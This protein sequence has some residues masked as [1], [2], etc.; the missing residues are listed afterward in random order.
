MND[1]SR[2]L[3]VA[4]RLARQTSALVL[5]YFGTGVRVD[6]KPGDE[7]VTEA[8]HAASAMIVAGL[9]SAFPDDGIL[10]EELPD[11]GAR[12]HKDRTWMVDPIDGTSDFIAGDDGFAVMIGLAV[13]GRPALGVVCQPTSGNLWAGCGGPGGPAWKEAADGARTALRTSALA[14]PPGI[15]LVASKSHRTR[16]VDDFRRALGISD[17][18]NVGGV[19]LKIG[20]VAEASRD[21]Y[22]YPGDRTKIWDTCAPE[23]ILLAAGGRLTDTF[24]EVL[25]YTDPDLH[26]RRGL[27]ASNG[28]LHD[29][30]LATLA[31]LRARNPQPSR[32]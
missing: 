25:R 30:V 32:P 3:D 5:R 9:H 24:G 29:L 11:D 15:R 28:T 12:F 21:L 26:N 14:E 31:E 22:V 1:L 18:T 4:C 2:E 17:E 8:D 16:D 20:L 23:A 10:S 7:P 19:G 27:V 13:A 6:R